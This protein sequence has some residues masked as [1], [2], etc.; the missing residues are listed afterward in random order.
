MANN[1]DITDLP[2]AEIV[3]SITVFDNQTR[4]NKTVTV[5][6]DTTNGFLFAL[7][8]DW[9]DENDYPFLKSP[10]GKYQLEIIE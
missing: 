3:T 5:F 8:D 10:Y 7:D 2:V 4:S 6:K 1:D 9:L